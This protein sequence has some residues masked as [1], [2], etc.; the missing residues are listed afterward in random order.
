MQLTTSAPRSSEQMES[1][2]AG[3]IGPTTDAA[4]THPSRWSPSRPLQSASMSAPDATGRSGRSSTNARYQQGRTNSGA[5][6]PQSARG[7]STTVSG[8]SVPSWP[9]T[10]NQ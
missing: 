10:A 7:S 3:S 5:C 9:M 6:S 2:T 1:W 8:R 4:V